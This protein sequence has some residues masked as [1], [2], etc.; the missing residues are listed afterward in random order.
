MRRKNVL[1]ALVVLTGV[2][3]GSAVWLKSVAIPSYSVSRVIDGDTFETEEHQLIRLASVDAPEREFCGGNQARTTLEHLIIGKP[4]YLK[5]LYRDQYNRLDSVVYT[6]DKFI[7]EEMVKSGWARVDDREHI[8]SSELLAADKIIRD[9]KKGIFSNLCTQSINSE[10]PECMI[11]GNIPDR[12]GGKK[13]YHLPDCFHYAS[14][15]MQLYQGDQWFCSERDAQIA[16]FQKA[17]G[18]P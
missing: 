7:N 1:S 11:K 13:W 5:V 2:A 3:I 10:H 17:G 6:K 12:G 18:C 14:V 4:V 16:G 9:S 15:I 8:Q